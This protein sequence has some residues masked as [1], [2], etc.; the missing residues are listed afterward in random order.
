MHLSPRETKG[1]HLLGSEVSREAQVRMD[2]RGPF[3]VR[4][5]AGSI[6]LGFFSI[7]GAPIGRRWPYL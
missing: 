4:K 2:L 3:P 5:G 7:G 6:S 1:G